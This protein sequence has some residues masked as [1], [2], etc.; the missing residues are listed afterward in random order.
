MHGIVLTEGKSRA[1][2]NDF[3]KLSNLILEPLDDL[4][5][6]FF[7]GLGLFDELPALLNLSPKHSDC[8][9]VLLCKLNSSLDSCRILQDCVVEFLAPKI[10]IINVT[11]TYLL[12]SLFSDS[13]DVFRALCNFSYSFLNFSMLWSPTSS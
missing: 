1:L 4:S 11:V 8:V 12:T 3:V 13:Y 5:S 2:L 6:L 7:F 10:Q 9:A